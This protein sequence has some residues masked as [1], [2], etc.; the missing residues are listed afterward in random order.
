VKA[1]RGALSGGPELVRVGADGDRAVSGRHDDLVLAR[2]R[3]APAKTPDEILEASAIAG[4]VPGDRH[5]RVAAHVQRVAA[6]RRL[7]N[8]ICMSENGERRGRAPAIFES[9]DRSV[10]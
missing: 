5:D 9:S 10:Q 3:V 7:P 2:R 8:A 4:A 1:V 6:K